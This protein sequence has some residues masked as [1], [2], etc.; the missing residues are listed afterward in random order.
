LPEVGILKVS[1][2]LLPVIGAFLN[3]LGHH[4]PSLGKLCLSGRNDRLVGGSSNAYCGRGLPALDN[5]GFPFG[6]G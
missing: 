1:K 5:G 3:V 2:T 4:D 6:A